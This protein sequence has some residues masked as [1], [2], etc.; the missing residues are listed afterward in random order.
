LVGT[1]FP[2]AWSSILET[3]NS[4][5][6]SKSKYKVGPNI[7]LGTTLGYEFYGRIDDVYCK[8][9][10]EISLDYQFISVTQIPPYNKS[11]AEQY[12]HVPISFKFLAF[13]TAKPKFQEDEEE[14]DLMDVL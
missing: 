4:S 6:T 5:S 7:H 1:G 14:V 12:L 3:K 8:W 11:L 10:P 9:G 13:T 2:W